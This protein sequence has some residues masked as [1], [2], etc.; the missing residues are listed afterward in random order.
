MT[1]QSL[2]LEYDWK[3]QQRFFA[4]FNFTIKKNNIYHFVLL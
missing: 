2:G 1:E 3:S 4:K